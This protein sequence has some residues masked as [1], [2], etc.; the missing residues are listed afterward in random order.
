MNWYNGL[1]DL[2][3]SVKKLPKMILKKH[4]FNQFIYSSSNA[5]S[6]QK[7]VKPPPPQGRV[8]TT[9]SSPTID[10]ST[11]SSITKTTIPISLKASS[12]P[13]HQQLIPINSN[14]NGQISNIVSGINLRTLS[15]ISFSLPVN[16]NNDGKFN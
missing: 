12:Q 16:A 15:P 13:S 4:F 9:T 2:I 7:G 11:A 10:T 1:F 5:S 3:Y 8:I 6:V 14:T